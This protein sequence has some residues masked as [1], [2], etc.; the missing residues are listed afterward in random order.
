MNRKNFDRM[1]TTFSKVYERI[2]EPDVLSIYYNVFKE[3]PDNQIDNIT[4]ECLKKCKYF[5]RPADVFGYYDRYT[6]E[7]REMRKTT[8]EELEISIQGIK[9][10]RKDLEKIS[11]PERIGDII[12]RAI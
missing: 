11:E 8:K 2:L 1:M 12:N 6:P 3:I 4:Q 5:P 9:R 10:A 7:K